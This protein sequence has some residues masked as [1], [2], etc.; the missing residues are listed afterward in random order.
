MHTRP[1]EPRDWQWRLHGA[2]EHCDVEQMRALLDT[3]G[4]VNV[5]GPSEYNLTV[6]GHTLDSEYDGHVQSA[7][8]LEVT[9]SAY[10]L[11]RGA[12]PYLEASSGSAADFIRTSDHWLASAFLTTWEW[13]PEHH[14]PASRSS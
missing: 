4:D 11:A 9:A 13:L 3:G 12:D 2:A 7:E 6:L 1:D 10:L 8:A 14:P 5:T